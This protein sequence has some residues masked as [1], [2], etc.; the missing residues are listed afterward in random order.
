MT[1]WIPDI[2]LVPAVLAG[3]PVRLVDL[4][5]PDRCWVVAGL[6]LAGL[7][8]EQIADRLGCSLRLVRSVRA[9]PTTAMAIWAITE[10]NHFADELRLARSEAARLLGELD[11]SIAESRRLRQQVTKLATPAGRSWPQCPKGKHSM[12]PANTYRHGGR[13]YCRGCHAERQSNYR[14]ARASCVV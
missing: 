1:R 9:E 12:N 10:A 11:T 3:R 5:E 8:A 7:T 2:Q 14:R 4:D 6:G 13:D